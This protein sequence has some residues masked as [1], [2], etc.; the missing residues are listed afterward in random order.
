MK[1]L[2]A[3]AAE[4]RCGRLILH[5]EPKARSL[6]ERL[7]FQAELGGDEMRLTLRPNASPKA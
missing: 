7:G 6:Y 2:M 5:T 4:K 3:S 1:R